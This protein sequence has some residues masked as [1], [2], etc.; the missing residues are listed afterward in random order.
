MEAGA[1]NRRW[2]ETSGLYSAG[3]TRHKEEKVI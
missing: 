2:I 1:Q 3:V